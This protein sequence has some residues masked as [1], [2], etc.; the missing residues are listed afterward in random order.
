MNCCSLW[1]KI[2][3]KGAIIFFWPPTQLRTNDFFRIPSLIYFCS[4]LSPPFRLRSLMIMAH[5]KL[6]PSKINVYYDTQWCSIYFL[7]K[8]PW[9][10]YKET[11]C[12]KNSTWFIHWHSQNGYYTSWYYIIVIISL[13]MMFEEH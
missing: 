13:K 4:L 6:N 12:L 11:L 10:Y 5:D 1:T 8:K 2:S 7:L 3:I 9:I